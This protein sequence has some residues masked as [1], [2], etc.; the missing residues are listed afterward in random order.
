MRNNDLVIQGESNFC[1]AYRQMMKISDKGMKFRIE[2]MYEGR[3]T[4]NLELFEKL[5]DEYSVTKLSDSYTVANRYISILKNALVRKPI[6]GSIIAN[7]F[8]HIY[9]LSTPRGRILVICPYYNPMLDGEY[10]CQKTYEYFYDFYGS[11][12]VKVLPTGFYNHHAKTVSIILPEW[13]MRE[14]Y[15][16]IKRELKRLMKT[17]KND[18]EC[19]KSPE[20]KK[21]FAELMYLLEMI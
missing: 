12:D 9:Q 14:H 17:F 16:R 10:V 21:R 15:V 6:S 13:V 18:S 7:V 2:Y 20:E 8:D 3:Y 11:L 5:V 1:D 19:M 4:Y